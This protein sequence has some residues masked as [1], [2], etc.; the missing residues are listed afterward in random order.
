MKLKEDHKEYVPKNEYLALRQT[1]DELVKS[2]EQLKQ[3]FRNAKVE[4]KCVVLLKNN[5]YSILK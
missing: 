4:Y 1:H 5:I 2:S 3:N